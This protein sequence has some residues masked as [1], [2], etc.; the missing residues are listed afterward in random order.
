MQIVKWNYCVDYKMVNPNV[1]ASVLVSDVL[2][3]IKFSPTKIVIQDI[4]YLIV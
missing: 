2:Y 4:A 3:Y 1:C